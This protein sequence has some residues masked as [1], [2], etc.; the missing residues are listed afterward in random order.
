MTIPIIKTLQELKRNLNLGP[1]YGGYIDLLKAL[2]LEEK[3]WKP[4]CNYSDKNYTRNCISS[5]EDY[6][7]ILMCWNKDQASPIHSY[8]FQEGWIKVLKGELTIET[9]QIDKASKQVEIK[10]KIVIVEGEYTYLNDNMGFHK[11][12]NTSKGE[13]ASLH[14]H[15]DRIDQWE[16]FDIE[17]KSFITSSPKYDTVTDDCDI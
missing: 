11:V 6:E 5:C 12:I 4:I 1:G 13:T 9:Y 3:E 17:N 15:I 16:V 8:D 10:E 2:K 14:L 7:L